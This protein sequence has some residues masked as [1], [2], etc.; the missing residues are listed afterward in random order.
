M[1]DFRNQISQDIK[2]YQIRYPYIKNIEKDEWAFNYWILDKF[3]YEDE[4][5]IEDK[6]LDYSDMGIDAYEFYEDTKDLYLIQNKYYT[7]SSKLSSE[8]VANDF[9]LRPI[10]A[11]KN[12]TYKRSSDLQNIFKKYSNHDDFT[13]Y[14]QIYVTNNIHCS[15]ADNYVKN[16]NL[17]NPK[18][19]A[20]ILYL[21][22]IEQKYYSE[23]KQNRFNLI[24][25]VESINKGTILNINTNDYKLENVLDAKYVFTPVTSIFRIY[26]TALE[27]NYPIFDM[28]IREYLGNKGVNKKIY[29]TLLDKEDRKNFFYYNNG[30]TLICDSMT[31]PTNHPRG[32]N[33]NV[34]FNISNPQIV[35]GC[36]TVNSIYE[37]L[38]NQDPNNLEK[39]YK[40]TFVM[41]KILQIDRKN[42]SERE[43]Y[44]NIVTYNNSQN[45]ID[46]KTF[47]SNTSIF[48][49][50]KTEFEDKG[51]LLLI[52]QSDKNSFKNIY[53]KTTKLHERSSER[54]K[55]F[56]LVDSFE[57]T[58]D[59]FIPLEKLLQVIIAFSMGG[60]HAYTKKSN[61]LK[62]NTLQYNKAIEFIKNPEVTIDA[63][64]D[65]YLL[66]KKADICKVNS[67]E[68]RFPIP[69]YLIDAFANYECMDRTPALIS[70]NLSSD[71]QID[72]II[73]LYTAVTNAY[74]ESIKQ[75]TGTEYNQ[76]IKKPVDYQVFANNRNILS[77]VL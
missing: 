26:R 46:E 47:V 17:D 35:N 49:R 53:S 39:E 74:T 40:D 62:Y 57:N 15:E 37:A 61:L 54:I 64:I 9:L 69:Y 68:N 4:E 66:Y 10:N 22:D 2:E 75:T 12:G 20:E 65:L 70:S 63:L 71:S 14:M 8:Y 33:I 27:K 72:K 60:Y 3:F 38:K 50:L 1:G 36:Q 76:M 19:R 23:T 31:S 44:K 59:Y 32:N 30:I 6:I 24:V 43:L 58:P 11:L 5:L 13:V 25:S 16:F 42:E 73:T 55:R 45:S 51:F 18:Y 34:S 77:R 52:K 48:N 56:G 41:L 29:S 21:D 28:N 7:D 67:Q